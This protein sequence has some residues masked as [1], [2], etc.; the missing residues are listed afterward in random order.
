MRNE[1]RPKPMMMRPTRKTGCQAC[2]ELNKQ[3]ALTGIPVRLVNTGNTADD[4]TCENRITIDCVSARCNETKE[5]CRSDVGRR[6]Q[7]ATEGKGQTEYLHLIPHFLPNRS[8]I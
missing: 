1:A 4:G 5:K 8:S 3:K 7:W 6:Q 2:L